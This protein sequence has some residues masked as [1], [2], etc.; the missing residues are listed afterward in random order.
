MPLPQVLVQLPQRV[1][2]SLVR[3]YRLL[4]K[5]WL[6]SA[7]RFEPTCSQFALDALT[8]H[9]AIVGATLTTGGWCGAYR[10]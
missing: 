2:I 3:G 4:F 9:G 1:L 5:P 6:G 8:R 10:S 7:C